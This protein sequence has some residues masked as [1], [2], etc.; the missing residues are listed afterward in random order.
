[1]AL[2]CL[3]LAQAI[4]TKKAFGRR[5]RQRFTTVL[6]WFRSLL[7]KMDHLWVMTAVIEHQTKHGHGPTVS[8]F[9]STRS[10]FLAI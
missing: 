1:M 3:W 5:I 7:N 8:D 4:A 10:K 2:R 6:Q 9:V